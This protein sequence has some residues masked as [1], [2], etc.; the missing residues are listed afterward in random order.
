MR[1]STRLFLFI[2]VLLLIVSLVVYIVPIYVLKRHVEEDKRNYLAQMERERERD[3]DHYALW[4]AD[5]IAYREGTINAFLYLLAGHSVIDADLLKNGRITES[6]WLGAARIM[7]MGDLLS[8]FQINQGETA[9]AIMLS[10]AELYLARELPID[11]AKSWV[12]VGSMRPPFNGA[13]YLGI[14]LPIPL[15][16]LIPTRGVQKGTLPQI[17]LLFDPLDVY[18]KGSEYVDRL[19]RYEKWL[20]TE[21]KNT[22]PI[23]HTLSVELFQRLEGARQYLVNEFGPPSV[24]NRAALH[25]YLE[26]YNQNIQQTAV[27]VPTHLKQFLLQGAPAGTPVNAALQM[28]STGTHPVE[29][30]PEEFYTM[31]F[32]RE[33]Q[34]MNNLTLIGSLG[35]LSSSGAILLSPFDPDGPVGAAR[36]LTEVG[37]GTAVFVHQAFSESIL[38]DAAG[39]LEP[40]LT[41][42][43][44]L[45]VGKDFA[46]AS[47]DAVGALT[48]VNSLLLAPATASLPPTYLTLGIS[49]TEVLLRLAQ[50]S[51]QTSLMIYN[52]HVIDEI[53]VPGIVRTGSADWL[54]VEQQLNDLHGQGFVTLAGQQFY[55]TVYEPSPGW[56]VLFLTL[57]PAELLLAPLRAFEQ[58]SRELTLEVSRQIIAVALGIFIVGLIV[59]ELLARHFTRPIATLARATKQVAEGKFEDIQLPKAPRYSKNELT[60]LTRSFGEMIAGLRDREKLRAVL[61]KVVSKEIADEILRGK[62]HLGGEVREATVLFA[63]IRGF[64]HITENLPPDEVIVFINSYMTVM[65]EIL[66]AYQGVIDKYVGDEIMALFGAPV[67]HQ[68]SA[69]QGILA[70][71]VMRQRLIEWNEERR[72]LGLVS[73]MVG[74][75]IN[76]GPMVAGNM[77]AEDRLNYTVMGANVNLAARLCQDAEGKEILIAEQMLTQPKVAESIV[78]EE[79]ESRTF[80]GFSHPIKVYRVIGLKDESQLD[81]LSEFVR[82]FG[83]KREASEKPNPP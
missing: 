36:L 55:Y 74:V 28:P 21:G 37:E 66:E 20:E 50:I 56:D 60:I 63:D 38:F 39:Y 57:E 47:P 34:R 83:L 26:S 2:A 59:L 27:G 29:L 41:G 30:T 51:G 7:H 76:T 15:D 42:R 13:L 43:E 64:T 32:L 75:G 82:Q 81:E 62:V 78:V 31:S 53:S 17:F 14:W 52:D 58:R 25:S 73:A 79:K 40:Q 8:F 49:L 6:A 80:K 77:G 11:A 22:S 18:E 4:L 70:A 1:L 46:L 61:N 68:Y 69:L 48:L 12:V 71:I 33:I 72:K 19:A 54:A 10:R 16:V 67:E 44:L 23:A 35:Y 5:Q 9:A 24:E 3:R 65:T 45:P